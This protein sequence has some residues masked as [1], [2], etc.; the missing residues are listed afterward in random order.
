[1]YWEVQ[2]RMVEPKINQRSFANNVALYGDNLATDGHHIEFSNS[3]PIVMSDY[4]TST[5][6]VTVLLEDYYNQTVRTDNVTY[7]TMSTEPVFCKDSVPAYVAGV[8]QKPLGEGSAEFT[9]LQAF[10]APE[11]TIPLYAKCTLN[12]RFVT[13]TLETN[14]SVYFVAC[15]PGEVYDNNV[16]VECQNSY[17]FDGST[18]KECPHHAT[19]CQGNRIWAEDG[20]WRISDTSSTLLRC[21]MGSTSCGGGN[22]SGNDLCLTG[23]EGPLCAV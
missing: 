9:S 1:M 16:C 4:Q 2:S 12:D 23:Y 8:L 17:T 6:A 11:Y 14:S 21:P 10:C 18:C 7:I 15:S 19:H 20:Y 22:A 3:R 5:V 13:T